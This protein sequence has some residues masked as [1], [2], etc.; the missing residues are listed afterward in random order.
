MSRIVGTK[1][2]PAQMPHHSL[3]RFEIHRFLEALNLVAMRVTATILLLD[4]MVREIIRMIWR[5]LK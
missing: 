5:N 3:E 2:P 4:E 1:L